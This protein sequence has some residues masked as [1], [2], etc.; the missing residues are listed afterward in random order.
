MRPEHKLTEV[1]CLVAD[2]LGLH[3]MLRLLLWHYSFPATL[4]EGG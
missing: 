1:I 3:L 4:V 2:E